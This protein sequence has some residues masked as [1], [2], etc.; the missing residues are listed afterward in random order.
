ME[1][2]KNSKIPVAAVVAK[3]RESQVTVVETSSGRIVRKER[4]NSKT[5]SELKEEEK[6]KNE[7]EDESN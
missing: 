7:L 4:M 2:R 6:K 1:P 5:K 3:E